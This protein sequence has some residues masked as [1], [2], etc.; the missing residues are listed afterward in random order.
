MEIAG[1]VP[2]ADVDLVGIGRVDR[3]LWP[4]PDR[5]TRLSGIVIPVTDG[6]APREREESA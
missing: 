1:T 3:P 2:G 4:H 6:A 5:R